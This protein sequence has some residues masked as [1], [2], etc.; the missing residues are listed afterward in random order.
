MIINKV[1]TFSE[2]NFSIQEVA[3][4]IEPNK[5]LLCDPYYFDIIDV[6]N[7]HMQN[8]E[9]K[10]DK[11]LAL[12]QW[13]NLKEVYQNL[14]NNKVIEE[15]NV[16]DGAPDCEDMVFAA[17]QSFPWVL[18]EEKIVIASKMFH[19]SRMKEVIHFENFYSRLGYKIKHLQHTS[20]FEGM[21]DTIPHP[22][23]NLLYGGFG[24]RSTQEAYSEISNLL[25]VP[26]ITLELKDPRFY[27]LDTCFL[28]LDKDNVLICK[29][30]FTDEGIQA[31][32]KTFLKI[33]PIPISEAITFFALNAHIIYSK[34]A[35]NKTAIIQQGTQVTL[36]ILKQNN[37]DV[38]EIDTSEY[39]KSGGSVF[40]MKIMIY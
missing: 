10:L 29:E 5:V 16:I 39:M 11:S 21:G 33:H 22:F 14:V 19:A 9:G 38:I 18:N 35:H 3:D 1:Y 2:I 32:Q 20:Y 13:G 37:V 24:H 4:R 34:S 8:Q 36:K 6:K 31:M 12:K 40:C 15:V 23:K 30:A 28:P 27:H 26:V 7:V 17:N 25:Q